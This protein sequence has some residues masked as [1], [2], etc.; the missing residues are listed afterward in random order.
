MNRSRSFIFVAFV[1]C[2]LPGNIPLRAQAP[3]GSAPDR[4]GLQFPDSLWAR[5]L[6]GLDATGGAIGYSADQMYGY[7]P[8]PLVL[9]TVWGLFRDVRAVP[10][11]SG[12]TTTA[13]LDNAHDAASVI[14]I[15]Y[16]LTDISAGRNLPTAGDS[17]RSGNDAEGRERVADSLLNILL[18]GTRQPRHANFSLYSAWGELPVHLRALVYQLYQGAAE[19]QEWFTGAYPEET[20]L[21]ALGVS[22][23]EQATAGKL[24]TLALKP[25][26]EERLGQPAVRDRFIF[27]IIERTD[28]RRLAFASVIMASHIR[29]AVNAYLAADSVAPRAV[30]IPALAIPTKFGTISI[31]GTGNDR[32]NG[33]A[34]ISI[35][36]G[37]DDL[38]SGRAGVPLSLASPVSLAIDF[39][40]ND[41]YEESTLPAAFGCGLFGFGAVVDVAGNDTYRCRESGLGAAWF[42]TG[43]LLDMAGNDTYTVDSLWGQGTAHIGVGALVDLAGDDRYV[44]GSQSQGLGSTLGAGL[45][46]DRSGNDVYIARDDGAIS[47]LYLGQSVSMSQGVGYGRRADLGDGHSLA[48]G[49][50]V[51][52]DGAGDD[53]YS[54]PVWSQGAGYWWG[55]GILEDRGG[56]DSYRSGKY[57]IGAAAHFAIGCKVDLAGDDSYAVGYDAAVNQ[58]NGHARDGSI[59]VSIDGDGNDRYFLKSHAAGSADLG[60]IGLFWDRRGDDQYTLVYAPADSGGWSDTPPLGTATLY[61]PFNSFRDDIRSYGLFIDSGGDDRY[62]WQEQGKGIVYWDTVPADGATWRSRRSRISLGLGLDGK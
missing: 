35:D 4:A 14:R 41:R 54:A 9:R 31:S 32:I 8:D 61:T 60:S 19:S 48:G 40:G 2:M 59:G 62:T 12:Q 46:V 58:Y 17:L 52:A 34:F 55:L 16:S 42:G 28:R 30:N 6:S 21:Q 20:I 56:N 15:G 53:S 22:T 23:R 38:Y 26:W 45:L 7:N 50:G 10:R 29:D 44:C 24:Y 57:S 3:A 36:L 39:G 49:V 18:K 33:T 5:A 25:W 51:L 27:D 11:Y 1:I 13:L 47:E 37:G 43:L